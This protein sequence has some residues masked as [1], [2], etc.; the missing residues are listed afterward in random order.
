[1][2]TSLYRTIN[3]DNIGFANK[4]S[5]KKNVVNIEILILN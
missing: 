2:K 1:M 3:F 4:N 5:Y